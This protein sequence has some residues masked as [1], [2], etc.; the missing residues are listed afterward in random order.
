MFAHKYACKQ[1]EGAVDEESPTIKIAPVPLKSSLKIML[2]QHFWP[3]LLLQSLLM[4]CR[5]TDKTS[6]K[7]RQDESY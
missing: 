6:K 4:L 1:C 3:T 2:L 5:F 7:I